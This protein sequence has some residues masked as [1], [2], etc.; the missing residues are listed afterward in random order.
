VNYVYKY[1]TKSNVEDF[2]CSNKWTRNS[3]IMQQ[4]SQTLRRNSFN[5]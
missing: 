1:P 2:Y 5:F 3:N 4:S